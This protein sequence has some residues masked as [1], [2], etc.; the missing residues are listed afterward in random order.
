MFYYFI[1]SGLCLTPPPSSAAAG[2]MGELEIH[3]FGKNSCFTAL[4]KLLSNALLIF[5]K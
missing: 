3:K 5:K 1:F 4:T 2:K